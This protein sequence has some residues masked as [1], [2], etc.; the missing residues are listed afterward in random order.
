MV[1]VDP[2]GKPYGSGAVNG[3]LV[4][5]DW[6]LVRELTVG[7]M[8]DTRYEKQVV[9]EKKFTV[10]PGQPFGSVQLSTQKSG[11]YAVEL[12]GKDAKGRESFTRLSF[13]STGSDEIV[14]QRSDERQLEIVPDK[15]I[16]APGDTAQLLIKSPLSKGTYLVSVERDGVLEKRTAG[17]GGQRTDHRR[18]HHRGARP[19]GVRVRVRLP[20][21]GRSRPPTGRTRR[22]SAS[23]AATRGSSR[24][25]WQTASRT[26]KLTITNAKDSYLPGTD[27]TVTMKAILNGQPLPGAE[28]VLVAADR[29]VLDLIDY[30]VPSPVD[31]FYS[32]GN[33]PDKV[34]HFDSRDMLMDPVTWKAN[35]LPGGD[36]KGES[37]PRALASRCGRTSTRPPCSA[38]GSSR[39]RTG[40]SS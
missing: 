28:I 11:S 38:P 13:Y 14:W 1:S 30:R 21:D 8:V 2:D 26:I 23:R 32:R 10:K 16:Y 39:E 3:R 20:R 35:D 17:P 9:E 15:K 36:E 19:H 34:A 31:F 37:A 24:S 22:T 7:G 5:E 25:R 4:R 29:G 12:S 40:R 6:K 27:A 18:A 33:F